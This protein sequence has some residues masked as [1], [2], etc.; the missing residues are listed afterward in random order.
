MRLLADLV[1]QL[2]PV[3]ADDRQDTSGESFPLDRQRV[4]RRTHAMDVGRLEDR[5]AGRR[6]D[7]RGD[8][9][10]GRVERLGREVV[11]LGD[12]PS[13]VILLDLLLEV[14]DGR[15]RGR[16]LAVVE[17][18]PLV[19][20]QEAEPGLGAGGHLRDI[21]FPV[22]RPGVDDVVRQERRDRSEI[23]RDIDV[24]QV[25]QAVDGRLELRGIGP[26][27]RLVILPERGQDPGQPLQGAPTSLDGLRPFIGREGRAEVVVDELLPERR[28]LVRAG[29]IGP[30][31][32][33]I[34]EQSALGP[35]EPN[36]GGEPLIER[37]SGP[38]WRDPRPRSRAARFNL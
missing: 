17:R 16:E 24:R 7:D 27:D 37:P 20:R 14:G 2:L 9:Q 32:V 38:G 25:V 34:F 5:Q 23:R 21:A 33:Y 3:Q 28:M 4:E 11:Q 29:R 19:A 13:S 22:D 26:G 8:R 15:V 31:G 35:G 18:D 10:M 6:P 1:E 30:M 12:L 36:P